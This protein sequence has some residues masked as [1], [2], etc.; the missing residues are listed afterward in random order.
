MPITPIIIGQKIIPSTRSLLNAS[1][2]PRISHNL[3]VFEPLSSKRETG[4]RG[5]WNTPQTTPPGFTSRAFSYYDPSM[6][7]PSAKGPVKDVVSIAPIAGEPGL[8]HMNARS[9]GT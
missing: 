7:D 6:T 1:Q 5:S 8:L 4:R 3:P 9:V 2:K